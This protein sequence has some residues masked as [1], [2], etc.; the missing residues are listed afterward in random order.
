MT[1]PDSLFFT[2]DTHFGH[3]AVIKYGKR[4]FA[5]VD[6][7]DAE[8]IRRWNVVVPDDGIVYHLG[9]VSFRKNAATVAI[10]KRLHGRKHLIEGNH[11]H[12]NAEAKAQFVDIANYRELKIDGRKI[13]LCHYPLESWNQMA[14][15]SWHLHGHSHGNLA[16][17][18]LRVDVGVDCWSQAP[19]SYGELVQYMSTKSIEARDHHT[20]RS[21]SEPGAAHE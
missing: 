2:G 12:L 10:L 8:L 21:G 4:P 17:F 6:E 14:Y 1:S 16:E 7:M 15:G 3:R 19:V 18:G 5:D 13:V 20:P 9:D 11:D